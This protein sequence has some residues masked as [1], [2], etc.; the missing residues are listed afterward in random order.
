MEDS[1]VEKGR[2]SLT[3]ETPKGMHTETDLTDPDTAACHG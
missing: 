2:G 1:R 3:P